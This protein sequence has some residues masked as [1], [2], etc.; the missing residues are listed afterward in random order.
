MANRPFVF[1]RLNW[2]SA[3]LVAMLFLICPE[4]SAQEDDGIRRGSSIIDDTTKSIYG[5]RT[6]R[7]FFEEEVFLNKE[8]LYQVDTAIRN[9]H[10]FSDLER[11]ENLY[12]DLGV[13]GT[14]IRPIYYESPNNIGVSSG[15]NTYDVYWEREKIRYWDTKSPYTNMQV[16]LGGKGRS[17]TRATYSR[18]ISPQWNFGLTYRGI[19]IDKQISRRGKGD[20]NVISHYYDFYTT[21]QSKD[22]TYRLFANIRRGNHQVA[23][24]GG[25]RTD[26]FNPFPYAEFFPIDAQPRLNNANSQELRINAHLFHQY[27]LGKG[28]QVYHVLDRYRQGNK[29]T[30]TPGSERDNSFDWREIDSL[31]TL[32]K[33]R[34]V[35]FRN[36]FGVKGSLSKLF[37]N[38]YYAIR[39]Y[40]MTYNNDTIFD[41]SSASNSKYGGIES[42][43]GG[44]IGLYLDSLGTLDG[45]AELM[46]TGNYRLQANLTSRWFEAYLKQIQYEPSFVQQ[47]Y[48]GAHDFWLNNFSPVNS[49][50]LGGAIHYRSSV[51]TLSPG[52]NFTRIGNYIF[53]RSTAMPDRVTDENPSPAEV[54]PFQSSGEQII[55]SPK[56]R[57]GITLWRHVHL[58]GFA[59][60]SRLLQESDNAIQIPELLVN[61]QLSYENIFFNGNLD[62]HMGV[63][64]HWKS[65]YYALAFD[66]PTRQFYVQDDAASAPINEYLTSTPDSRLARG[67]KLITPSFPIVNAFFNAKIKRGRVFFRY[68]NII[69]A[70]TGEGYFATPLYP[71]Q[72]NTLDFG[73]DWSFYD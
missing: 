12:Q 5:P 14:D 25:I 54:L 37:Y 27:A 69:Q 17:I 11:F 60:Y 30:G 55:F 41:G 18:N 7:Y 24:Q 36:E 19:F 6:S 38:G 9:F 57:L 64:V 58:R 44:R 65:D 4:V 3:A 32:D 16:I 43:L 52:L 63:D 53:Y 56:L 13:I 62:M 67:N 1:L 48:R 51:L 61:G 34:F 46:S 59:M 35:A 47:Y 40:S 49:T 31:N 8:K 45:E 21:Y 73:F 50:E 10:Q 22:S 39:N 15:F 28:L 42:Y 71:G 2:L 29:F 68:N 66:V 72:R 23:E 33:T 26:L 70:I 20:R